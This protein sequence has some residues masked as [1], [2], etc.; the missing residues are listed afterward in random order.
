MSGSPGYGKGAVLGSD[1][2]I[3]L[4]LAVDGSH[5]QDAIANITKH[6]CKHGKYCRNTI[7]NAHIAFFDWYKWMQVLI[8]MPSHGFPEAGASNGRTSICRRCCF[9]DTELLSYQ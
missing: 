5:E 7:R 2:E 8:D 4:K 9:I 1:G 6:E 3:V